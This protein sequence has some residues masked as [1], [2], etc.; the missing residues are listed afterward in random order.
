MLVTDV[1]ARGLDIPLLDN[2]INYSFPP[3]PKLFVHRVEAAANFRDS[4]ACTDKDNAWLPPCMHSVRCLPVSHI[5]FASVTAKKRRP[6]K[7]QAPPSK[8]KTLGIE[9][10]TQSE[11]TAFLNS[12]NEVEA[13]SAVLAVTKSYNED[14]IKYSNALLGQMARD[15]PPSWDPV[16][17][18]CDMFAQAFVVEPKGDSGH[19]RDCV[20][21][22]VLEE[23]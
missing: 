6:D 16:L 21:G 7:Q 8:K 1:A 10:P 17:A 5:D 14:F 15:K 3:R 19:W 20:E 2:V 22:L 13:Q 4:Q 9:K 18:E 23:L 11:W 12:V